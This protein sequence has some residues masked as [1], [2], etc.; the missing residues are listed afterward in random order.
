MF[1]LS[2]QNFPLDGIC[3]LHLDMSLEDIVKIYGEPKE[4][5]VVKPFPKPEWDLICIHYDYLDIYSYRGQKTVNGV[6]VY[7]DKYLGLLDKKYIHCG[8]TKTEI[9]QCFGKGYF[10][11]KD[12]KDEYTYSYA[13]TDFRELNCYYNQDNTLC[14]FYFG[15]VN[16]E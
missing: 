14:G 4:K 15:Y 6:Y 13:L 5:Y 11:G 1:R 12:T 2:C 8:K 3:A 16:P 9:E 7:S 10:E